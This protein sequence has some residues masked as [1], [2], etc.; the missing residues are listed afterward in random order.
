MRLDSSVRRAPLPC[1]ARDSQANA[2]PA[3]SELDQNG[4]SI[5]CVWALVAEFCIQGPVQL[6]S[7]ERE[8]SVSPPLYVR[9][10]RLNC[11]GVV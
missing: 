5:A 2:R 1:N 4:P 3:M 9:K 8:P 6:S 10:L 7:G 11:H